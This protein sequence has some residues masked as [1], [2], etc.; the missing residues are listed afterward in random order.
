MPRVE[1]DTTLYRSNGSV[2]AGATARLRQA[3]LAT[4]IEVYAAAT[5]GSPVS[6]PITADSE[7]RIAGF[8]ETNDNPFGLG[9]DI[10]YVVDGVTYTEAINLPPNAFTWTAVTFANSWVNYGGAHAVAAYGKTAE[11]MVVLKGLVKDGTVG[12]T[13]F[14]LP[15]DFR[16]AQACRF[17]TIANGAGGR[18]DITTGGAVSLAT[19]GSNVYV[20]LNHILFPVKA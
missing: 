6:Q 8:L 1:I 14:T 7:G 19:G 16:P 12:S 3:G 5:G 17:G 4:D 13:M 15:A 9:V 10:V 2:A 20:S 18:I 11:G